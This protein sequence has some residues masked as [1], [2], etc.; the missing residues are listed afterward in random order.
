MKP[1]HH[2]TRGLRP[3]SLAAW[4]AVCG[5]FA[6]PAGAVSI[7]F[8]PDSQS[9]MLGSTAQVDV[10][11]SD[12]GGEVI[13]AYDLDIS[14]DPAVLDA[15]GVLFST[16]LGD[17]FFFE[18]FNDFD[19]STAGVVDLAQLSLL[20]DAELLALQG[21]DSVAVATLFVDAIGVGTTELDFVF[22]ALN[23]VKGSNGAILPVLAG[24]G[25][26]S[27]GV[28]GAPI[29]EPSATLLFAVGAALLLCALRGD[30]YRPAR[31][32]WTIQSG[33]ASGG[34]RSHTAGAS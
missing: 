15:S 19:L 18:V 31:W 33:S 5:A 2:R 30:A 21:G 29:P 14:Y 4:L 13:S 27:V 3:T 12:L 9:L 1:H 8:D 16:A 11:F 7:G 25:S 26:I 17:E 23:D 28:A 34:E 10:V 24:S 20:S 22:D 32:A 6:A